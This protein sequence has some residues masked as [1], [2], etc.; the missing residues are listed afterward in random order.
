MPRRWLGFS[1]RI[2]RSFYISN[3]ANFNKT[4]GSLGAIA[5]LMFWF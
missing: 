1:R 4:Y 3:F 2:C 5:A